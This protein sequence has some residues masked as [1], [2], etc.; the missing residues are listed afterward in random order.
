MT[1]LM[2]ALRNSAK[3]PG[4]MSLYKLDRQVRISAVGRH[5]CV[6]ALTICFTKHEGKVREGI[7]ATASP[8]ATF[9][10]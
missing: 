1:K 6:N 4:R 2:V 5:C 10:V 7:K 3:A 8:S 9:L